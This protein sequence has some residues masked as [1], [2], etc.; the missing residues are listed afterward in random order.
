M[1]QT[2]ATILGTTIAVGTVSSLYW[3]Y[4]F[5]RS[6]NSGTSSSGNDGNDGNDNNNNSTSSLSFVSSMIVP[7][8]PS[9][10]SLKTN[11]FSYSQQFKPPFPPKIRTMLSK[12]RLA[13]LSTVDSSSNSSHL[14]L[15]RFT[16]VCDP[17]DGEVV[18]MS[19]NVK[20]K[21]FDMLAQQSGVALLV[22]DFVKM[23]DDDDDD[24]GDGGGANDGGRDE[25]NGGTYSMTLNGQCRIL[26]NGTDL[27]EKYRRAHLQ[28]NPEYPQ[29]IVGPDIVMLCV[30]V[31]SARIC[32]IRDQVTKWNVKDGFS[33]S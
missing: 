32:D 19:T 16:Y 9:S 11:N 33:S 21:K 20:T 26:K 8:S 10:S 2:I 18:V 6:K 3:W 29:F 28:H 25:D 5:T 23:P 13:Y 30:D 1:K 24:G 12:C 7:S 31:T 14:S 15:M 4:Y 17:T 22:H 27:A